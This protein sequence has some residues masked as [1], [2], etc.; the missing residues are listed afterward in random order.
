MAM[1]IR[2]N[3]KLTEQLRDANGQITELS[4]RCCKL[5]EKMKMLKIPPE[6]KKPL[7]S[8]LDVPEVHVGDYIVITGCTSKARRYP[9]GF[10]IKVK[11]CHKNNNNGLVT[12]KGLYYTYFRDNNTYRETDTTIK[13]NQYKWQSTSATKMSALCGI[14]YSEFTY[15]GLIEGK[16]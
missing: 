14:G 10:V 15:S 2:E 5:E 7:S 1:L 8:I 6:Q 3:R 16:I 13:N 12:V 4:V 11:S 9:N